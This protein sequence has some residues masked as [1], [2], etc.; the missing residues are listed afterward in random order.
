[1]ELY[2]LNFVQSSV[3]TVQIVNSCFVLSCLFF[4]FIGKIEIN[5]DR[6][7][8]LLMVVN[9]MGLSLLA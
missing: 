8:M 6:N 3:S 5:I 2:N 1:M 9:F 4:C 7:K